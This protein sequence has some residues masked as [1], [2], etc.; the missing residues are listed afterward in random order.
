MVRTSVF[1]FLFIVVLPLAACTVQAPPPPPAKV[2]KITVVIDSGSSNDRSFN[3]YTTEGARR[4][5]DAA[6]VVLNY[7]EP[8]STSD[9]EATIEEAAADQADLIITVGFRMGEAT[10]KV[11]RR[12]PGIHF[13]I[14]DNAY[15]PG[16]GCADTVKDCYTEAGGL[17]NVTSLMFA[18]DE[19][20]YLAGTLA[21]CMSKNGKVA[22]VAGMEIPPVVRFV[23]GFQNGALHFNP[24]ITVFN[25][26]IPDFNDP[27]MGKV[28]GQSFI[29]QGADV[30]FGAAGNTG[31]GAL[32]AAKEAGLMAIGVDVDQYYTYPEV[33]QA[34]LTSASK[35]VDVA[36]EQA[37]KEFIA[38][39]LAGGIRM[40]DL[41]N[42]GI[43]LAPYHDWKQR[44]PAQCKQAISEAQKALIADPSLAGARQ[45]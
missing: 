13:I 7:R 19:V 24:Q 21:A 11:A 37:V 28:V 15:Y 1:L 20:A 38:G 26:Y 17:P 27:E 45:P 41:A 30:L 14:I 10:A 34:L 6:H 2:Q 16:E 18:E 4:A 25:Q 42:G 35:N 43:G 9:Y 39:R 5:A 12:Y 31:N 8:Q 22:S 29:N 40:A 3:Q 32:L 33:A 44:I 23:T 36:A